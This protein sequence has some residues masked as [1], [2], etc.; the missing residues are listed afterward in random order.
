MAAEEHFIPV[1]SK[2]KTIK[3]HFTN[4]KTNAKSIFNLFSSGE[5]YADSCIRTGVPFT[6]KVARDYDKDAG[7]DY[8]GCYVC[9]FFRGAS[10]RIQSMIAG[11]NK[12]RLTT[13]I[14]RNKKTPLVENA[15]S[16]AYSKYCVEC[17]LVFDEEEC[18]R[19]AKVEGPESEFGDDECASCDYWE[20]RLRFFEGFYNL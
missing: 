6:L 14:K 4:G 8:S 9:Y 2:D 15:T 11:G 12:T 16:Q 18:R 17:D 13:T 7:I 10:N 19:R 5:E 20:H 3:V 1:Q